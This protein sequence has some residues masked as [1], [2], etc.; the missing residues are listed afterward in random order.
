MTNYSIYRY[1]VKFLRVWRS[2]VQK[3]PWRL[4]VMPWNDFVCLSIF[5]QVL[6]VHFIWNSCETWL[7]H[8]IILFGLETSMKTSPSTNKGSFRKNLCWWP[9][10]PKAVHLRMAIDGQWPGRRPVG[11]GCRGKLSYQFQASEPIDGGPD[12]RVWTYAPSMGKRCWWP[13]F[14]R[15]SLLSEGWNGNSTPLPNKSIGGSLRVYWLF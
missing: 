3:H 2:N 9:K 6:R 1:C 12:G 11:A 10:L 14:L 4:K 13:V 8:I 7:N 5:R 15:R